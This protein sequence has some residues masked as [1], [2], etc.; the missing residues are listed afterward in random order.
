MKRRLLA[1]SLGC[2][3]T[4][5]ASPALAEDVDEGWESPMMGRE[6]G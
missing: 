5:P 6:I 3:L 2:L 1:I 4:L